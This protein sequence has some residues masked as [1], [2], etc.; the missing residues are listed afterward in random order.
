MSSIRKLACT[1]VGG[2][3]ACATLNCL[4]ADPGLEQRLNKLET[5]LKAQQQEIQLLK[6]QLTQQK[7]QLT[8]QEVQVSAVQAAQTAPAAADGVLPTYN[9]ALDKI[10]FKNDLRLR[11]QHQTQDNTATGDR[12]R[13]LYRFRLRL[14]GVYA[15]PNWQLGVK[16]SSGG[17]SATSTNQTFGDQA[18][19]DDFGTYEIRID[20]AYA[21][22]TGWGCT[23]VVAGK[24]SNPFE[25]NQMIWDTDLNPEGVVASWANNLVFGNVGWFTVRDDAWDN[26]TPGGSDNASLY[27]LQLG[28]TPSIGEGL[29]LKLGA[30]Y[31]NFTSASVETAVGVAADDYEMRIGELFA[32]VGTEIGQADVS[33]FAKGIRNFGANNTKGLGQLGMAGKAPKDNNTGW[34]VGVKTGLGR[35]GLEYFYEKLEGDA[36]F[37]DID[38]GDFGSNRK[39][40]E[41][42]LSYKASDNLTLMV[43]AIFNAEITGP[44]VDNDTIQLDAI[45]KF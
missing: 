40:H 6:A 18:D 19:T 8:E 35:W 26:D 22:Y 27:G 34:L 41:V 24:F 14:G 37:D 17:S 44:S 10:T 20:Q 29:A 42:I 16:L 23:S 11:Y 38:D 36:S 43:D 3:L 21:K 33:F 30:S 15:L 4:G 5:L 2:I 39:G 31:Y 28:L 45:W 1:V 12:E 7:A 25:K 32:S 9:S 13:D